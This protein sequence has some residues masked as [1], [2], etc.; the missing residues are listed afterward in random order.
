M[1]YLQYS[2]FH[3]KSK[4]YFDKIQSGQSF[5]ITRNGKPVAQILPLN[6]GQ[7]L[8]SGK[9]QKISGWKRKFK[10]IKLRGNA[11]TLD[12]ILKGRSR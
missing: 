1:N 6:D 5:I 3:N 7:Q 4:E 2:E 12:Y 8:V 9:E 11:N 10:P